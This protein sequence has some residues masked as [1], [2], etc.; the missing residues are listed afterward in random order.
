MKNQEVAKIFS[1]VA[2]ILEIKGEN[3]FRIRAYRKAALNIEEL[4]EDIAAIAARESLEK[5]PGIGKDLAGKILEIIS[6]G[7]CRDYESLKKL[8][9]P[10]I[11]QILSIPGV[12]P[13]TAGI[14][15]DEFGISSV[16]ELEKLALEHKIRGLKGMKAKTEDNILKGIAII[17]KGRERQPLGAVLP[18]AEEIISVLQAKCPGCRASLAGSLRRRRET[19][20]DI[21]LLIASTKPA[22]VMDAFTSLIISE[23]VLARGETKSSI[24]T[25]NGI[26]VD[27]RVV[28]PESWGAALCYFTG[29][30]A[31]NIRIRELA[32]RKGL[33]INEYGV[34]RGEKKIAGQEEK[35]VF[36]TVDLP[37]IPPELR[38]DRG[39]IAAAQENRLPVLVEAKDLRG[40]L[41]VHSKFSDGAA[42]LPDIASKA[43]A[44]GLSWVLITDHSQSLKVARGLSIG[45]LQR[46]I[47]AIAEFNLKSLS[48]KLLC[49]TEVDIDSSGNLDYP[50]DI[51]RQL[52]LV[53]ASIHSGFKQDEQTITNRIVKAMRN[54]YVHIIG[55][56]SGRL[57]GEREPYAVNMGE[58]FKVAAETHTALEINAYFKRLDLNDLN[59]RAAK[60]RGC[61]LAIGSDAHIL[62][63]MN[64]TSLGVDTAR[65]AWLTRGDLLNTLSYEEIKAYGK[66]KAGKLI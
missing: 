38:E 48:L 2:D 25:V 59:A 60:E 43:E 29:S 37:Y 44:M 5:I 10:G 56:P 64:F 9:A 55:H 35:D 16:E 40:D 52:D 31:H 62:E 51:L 18:V 4:T 42:S 33:K 1:E 50:D 24:R 27:L 3:P 41:H 39:E 54:P 6:T 57:I 19:V 49:G 32:V 13:R 65:R 21:D 7:T 28:E 15:H 63:Q 45:D 12:G 53:V 47:A 22:E 17:K 58:V 26:Q 46:K 23:E 20:K 14:L 61:K 36:S 8:V 30:K 11:I 66:K 34:F